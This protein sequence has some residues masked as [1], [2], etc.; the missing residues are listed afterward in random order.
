MWLYGGGSVV[1]ASGF[2]LRA[3][4]LG[5]VSTYV[6]EEKHKKSVSF[7]ISDDKQRCGQRSCKQWQPANDWVPPPHGAFNSD[8]RKYCGRTRLS[9]NVCTSR[10]LD[11]N[12]V[13]TLSTCVTPLRGSAFSINSLPVSPRQLQLQPAACGVR[14]S[15]PQHPVQQGARENLG[16][17]K[18]KEERRFFL[19]LSSRN[20]SANDQLAFLSPLPVVRFIDIDAFVMNPAFKL[21]W[22]LEIAEKKQ[23]VGGMED[24]WGELKPVGG[25]FVLWGACRLNYF[26][27]CC[28]RC[29]AAAKDTV[30]VF[31]F[32]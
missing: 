30:V 18:T 31:F 25:G 29:D 5:N 20:S 22:L 1:F 16:D 23:Q 24:G 27:Y 2:F 6:P 15:K 13:D 17:T 8:R 11:I 3:Q 21:E 28:S 9:L 10:V 14:R 26:C 32:T 7:R 12:L 4:I 19:S